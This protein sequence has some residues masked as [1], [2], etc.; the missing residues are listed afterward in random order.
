MI[1]VVK[2][3]S[4]NDLRE[5]TYNFLYSDLADPARHFPQDL[6]AARLQRQMKMPAKTRQ[7]ERM[8]YSLIH[9]PGFQ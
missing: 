7:L 2:A 4:G 6:V 1:S 9:I 3:M 8:K 5:L